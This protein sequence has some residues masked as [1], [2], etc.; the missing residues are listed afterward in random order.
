MNHLAKVCKS[1]KEKVHLAE[2][3]EEYDS[4]VLLL[5]IEEVTTIKG[6]G[7]QL[8]SSITFLVEGK[9]SEQCTCQLD[10]SATCNVINYKDLRKSAAG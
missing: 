8:I 6:C 1:A 9:Y 7:K 3:V 4:E 10:T 2:E 5:K